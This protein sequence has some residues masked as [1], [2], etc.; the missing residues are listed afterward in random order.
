MRKFRIRGDVMRKF[1]RSTIHPCKCEI[2]FFQMVIT[3]SFQL[4]VKDRLKLWTPDFPIFETRYSTHEIN[5]GKWS[6]CA[7]KFPKWGGANFAQCSHSCDFRTE[8]LGRD[9]EHDFW[10]MLTKAISHK[11][12]GWCE[13]RTRELGGANCSVFFCFWLPLCWSSKNPS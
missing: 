4:Q 8:I 10:K 13:F 7:Q 3:S 5:F 6:K 9:R 2:G 1:R 11:G 12:V